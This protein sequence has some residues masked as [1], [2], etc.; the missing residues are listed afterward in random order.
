MNFCIIIGHDKYNQGA[1]SAGKEFTEYV[2]NKELA[3]RIS[4]CLGTLQLE[5]TIIKKND[6]SN[7]EVAEIIKKKDAV[8]SIELHANSFSGEA[9]GTEVLYTDKN[10]LNGY[11]AKLIQ[12]G[13][14]V[15]LDRQGKYNRGT[16]EIKEGERGY[17]NI[18]LIE[19]PCCLL[20]PFFID[21][22]HDLRLGVF[23]IEKIAKSI[24][25]SMISFI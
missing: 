4:F 19:S 16:K 13:L 3:K 20:E 1:Q 23:E 10:E 14:A 2:Y 21:N 25:N 6:I 8:C 24:S 12:N 9:R 11:L 5:P 7:L 22:I 18:K 15:T 17:N